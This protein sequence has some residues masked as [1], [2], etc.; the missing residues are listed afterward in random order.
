[1]QECGRQLGT[2]VRK[3]MRMHQEMKKRGYI[4][5]YLPAIGE[6]LR[7]ILELKDKQVDKVCQNLKHVLEHSRKM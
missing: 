7:D 1:L 6:A 4:E 3:A 5:K 2:Y